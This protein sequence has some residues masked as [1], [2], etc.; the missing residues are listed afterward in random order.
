[1]GKF[2]SS[3]FKI[4]AIDSI[5]LVASPGEFEARL[6]QGIKESKLGSPEKVAV[7]CGIGDSMS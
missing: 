4:T 2:F 5:C 7:G 1:M 6:S 3:I